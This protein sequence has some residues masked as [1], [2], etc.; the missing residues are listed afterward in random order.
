MP[1]GPSGNESSTKRPSSAMP[2]LPD[3][4]KKNT[5]M[6]S[7]PA[8]P[9]R[10]HLVFLLLKVLLNGGGAW[11]RGRERGEGEGGGIFLFI[12][13]GGVKTFTSSNVIGTA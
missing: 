6:P 10:K 11:K 8:R 5:A 2:T 4:K 1:A 12:P 9:P 13:L 3:R 7:L